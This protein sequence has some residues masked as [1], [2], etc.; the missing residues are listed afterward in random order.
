MDGEISF[1]AELLA[2]QR[3]GRELAARK[4]QVGMRDTHPALVVDT[5]FPG[6]Q[7]YVFVSCSGDS[8]TWQAD[9]RHS[10]DDPLGAAEQIVA[11]VKSWNAAPGGVRR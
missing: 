1:D 7:L 6:V 11:Y 8:F 3:L 2:L 4:M 9:R 10:V 5:R